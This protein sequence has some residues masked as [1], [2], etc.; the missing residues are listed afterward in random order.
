LPNCCVQPVSACGAIISS[1]GPSTRTTRVRSGPIGVELDARDGALDQAH[2]GLRLGGQYEQ[3][4]RQDLEHRRGVG[5][6]RAHR[7]AHARGD[8]RALE[9]HRLAVHAAAFASTSTCIDGRVKPSGPHHCA[10][11]SGSTR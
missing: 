1:Y 7:H 5:E 4:R 11:R 8:L 9:H 10:I 2:L 3:L 6:R